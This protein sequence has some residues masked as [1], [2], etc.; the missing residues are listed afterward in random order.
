MHYIWELYAETLYGDCKWKPTLGGLG[1][2]EPLS[3]A[4][5]FVIEVDLPSKPLNSVQF[6]CHSLYNSYITP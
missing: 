5:G 6:L 2:D 4:F 1:V 3:C